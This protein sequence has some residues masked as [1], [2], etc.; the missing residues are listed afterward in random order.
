[1]LLGTML[2][3]FVEEID[4]RGM[5]NWNG[6]NLPLFLF[7]AALFFIAGFQCSISASMFISCFRFF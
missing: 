2:F 6:Q 7:T 3:R 5:S 4:H 1:M